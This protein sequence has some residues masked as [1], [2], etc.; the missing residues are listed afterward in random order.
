MTEAYSVLLFLSIFPRISLV[1]RGLKDL[2]SVGVKNKRATAHF[3]F[4]MYG[5]GR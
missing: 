4:D 3:A 1:C 5:K 2:S